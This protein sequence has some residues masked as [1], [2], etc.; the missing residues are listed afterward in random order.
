MAI[1][2]VCFVM[3]IIL[4]H[5]QC[6]YGMCRTADQTGFAQKDAKKTKF[7]HNKYAQKIIMSRRSSAHSS[8]MDIEYK[9]QDEN[10]LAGALYFTE[11]SMQEI[12]EALET[13]RIDQI[14]NEKKMTPEEQ[15]E[16]CRIALIWAIGNDG[17]SP[18]DEED[19][20][21]MTQDKDW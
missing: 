1:N 3:L 18:R 12:A 2:K 5:E 10:E 7:D 11:K 14:E 6:I 20:V 13:I 19:R 17:T 16:F 8:P 21:L 15:E 4:M 9:Q